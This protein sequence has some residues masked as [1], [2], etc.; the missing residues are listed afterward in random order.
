[1]IVMNYNSETMK[2]ILS[3]LKQKTIESEKDDISFIEKVKEVASSSNISMAKAVEKLNS[4]QS[5]HVD[6]IINFIGEYV[7]NTKNEK[8]LKLE[9]NSI[10]LNQSGRLVGLA[11]KESLLWIDGL[12]NKNVVKII[13]V[14]F[15]DQPFESIIHKKEEPFKADNKARTL[16][17]TL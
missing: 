7:N 14:D 13:D 1:M 9:D 2:P 3:F 5:I 15:N 16:K 10:L 12:Y 6:S 4:F 11:H 17:L 8:A